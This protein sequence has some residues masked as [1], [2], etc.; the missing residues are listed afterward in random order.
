[1]LVTREFIG[2]GLALPAVGVRLDYQLALSDTF[3]LIFIA[4]QIFIDAAS[5][6]GVSHTPATTQL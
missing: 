2:R 5:M 1:M 6:R 4:A 3:P